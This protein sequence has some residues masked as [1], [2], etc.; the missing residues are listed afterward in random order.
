MTMNQNIFLKNIETQAIHAA[1]SAGE[2]LLNYF[3]KA[4]R[5]KIR[6]KRGAGIVTQADMAA[7]KKIIQLLSRTKSNCE[8]IGEETGHSN[9]G[10]KGT[11]PGRWIVDPLDGTT[12]FAHGFPMFCVSIGAQ[13]EGELIVG[14]IY[15]PVLKDLYVA[16]KGKGAKLNGKRIKV[17]KTKSIKKSLLTTG[18]ACQ[19]L[20][21]LRREVKVFEKIAASARGLRRPGSAALDLAYTA[22][23]VFDGFWEMGLNEWDL[24]AGALLVQEAGGQV[25]GFCGE[26]FD[27]SS[28]H[29][30]ASNSW[31]H[32][33]LL[34]SLKARR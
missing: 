9:K 2:I 17:S 30:V 20:K 5:L 15:H 14:V 33:Y 31:L 6:E 23:G 21:D 22:R 10:K 27:L 12:N 28:G 8:F 34:K 26:T 7:E 18:F 19:K 3:G 25:T 4:N 1:Q 11:K 29:I 32:P 24:A 13:W 16:V